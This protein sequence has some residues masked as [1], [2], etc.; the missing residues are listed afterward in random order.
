MK[1]E[2]IA[3]IPLMLGLFF[4]TNFKRGDETRSIQVAIPESPYHRINK[5]EGGDVPQGTCMPA[6]FPTTSDA[7]SEGSCPS[8]ITYGGAD[9][10]AIYVCDLKLDTGVS[11]GTSVFYDRFF[12][13]DGTPYPVTFE[14]AKTMCAQQRESIETRQK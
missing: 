11:I 14:Q 8:T 6:L 12:G 10:R 9:A 5:W 1:I 13:K 7:Y 3:L 4:S 2:S